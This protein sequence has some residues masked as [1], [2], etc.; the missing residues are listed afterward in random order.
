MLVI[1]LSFDRWNEILGEPVIT[2][3]LVDRLT[4]QIFVF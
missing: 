2:A 4:R 3:T 1:N